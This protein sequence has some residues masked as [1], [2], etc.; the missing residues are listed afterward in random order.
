MLKINWFS[1][2]PPARTG[3]ADYTLSLLSELATQTHSTADL[4]SWTNQES[5][6]STIDNVVEV[7]QFTASTDWRTEFGNA[8]NIYNI[9]NNSQ[10]HTWIWLISREYPGIIILHDIH[11]QHLF[12]AYY[13]ESKQQSVYLD[14]MQQY[15]G[16]K[17][18]EDAEQFFSGHL[19]IN[20]LSENYPLFELAIK[21]NKGVIVHTENAVEKLGSRYTVTYLPLP[22]PTQVT[23]NPVERNKHSTPYQLIIFGHLGTNRR[24]DSVLRA[25]TFFPKKEQF[26]L[27]IYGAISNEKEIKNRIIE[28]GLSDI[29]RIHGFVDNETLGNALDKADL[30]VNLRHPTMGEASLSQLQIWSHALPSIVTKTG[31][32]AEQ[33]EECVSF[34]SIENEIEDIVSALI[35]F[36][37]SPQ[38]F[39]DKG[40]RGFHL[41]K[42]KHSPAA[43]VKNL[44][45]YC[46][47]VSQNIKRSESN[48]SD[49]S[50]LLWS[51]KCYRIMLDITTLG[52]SLYERKAR[53]G[54][55]VVT[56]KILHAL[57]LLHKQG[58]LHVSFIAYG[59]FYKYALSYYLSNP[60][61]HCVSLYSSESTAPEVD[62]YHCPY[63]PFPDKLSAKTFFL[64][65]YDLIPIKFSHWFP[66]KANVDSVLNRTFNFIAAHKGYALS[67]SDSTKNDLLE[68]YPSISKE[69]AL[70]TEL[71]ADSKKFYPCTEPA[72]LSDVY[73]KYQ[74]PAAPY[75][76]S[77]C[78]LEPRKNLQF[79]IQGFMRL[80][81]ENKTPDLYLVLVGTKGWL[82]DDIFAE[83]EKHP[84]YKERIIFTGYVPD[85]DLAPLY[86]GALA[87][88]YMS[89]Y[90]GFG[91]PPLE[92]MQ[93]GT[94]VITS[95]TSSLPEVVGEGGLMLDPTDL[96]A[97]CAA[98]YEMH[99]NPAH[100]ADM[101]EKALARAKLFSWERF[102]QQTLDAYALAM[103]EHYA[104]DEVP[105]PPEDRNVRARQLKVVVDGVF[106]Q[107]FKTG[108]A[109]VW[110]TL[111]HWWVE[112]G[113][114]AHLLVLDRAGSLPKFEGVCRRQIARHDYA[115]LDEDR[116]LLQ[117]ICIE[118][119]ADIFISSYYT[120]PLTTP[121]VLLLHDMIPEALNAQMNHPM[122]AEK[123]ECIRYAS[124]YVCISHNTAADLQRFFPQ[125][126]ADRVS[127][128]WNGVAAHFFPASIDEI[129]SFKQKYGIKKPYFFVPGD[130]G[131]H[132]NAVLF[133]QA[134][135][136]LAN[137]KDLAIV[138]TRGKL[139]SYLSVYVYGIETHVLD[140][141]D[142][143]LRAAY[144]GA[145]A[146]VFPS[147]YE[148]FGLPVVEAFA[149]GCP[150]VSS[151]TPAIAEVAGDAAILVDPKSVEQLREALQRV[152][153]A[154]VREALM[155]QGFERKSLFSWDVLA[156]TLEMQLRQTAAR[157]PG[158]DMRC[159]PLHEQVRE[160]FGRGDMAEAYRRAE[161]HYR[162]A[163]DA[164]ARND[165]AAC[166]M[167]QEKWQDA[168]EHLKQ[169]IIENPHHQVAVLNLAY[170][171]IGLSLYDEALQLFAA[172][173][174]LSPE[175]ESLLNAALWLAAKVGCGAYKKDLI[176]RRDAVQQARV[177]TQPAPATP[178][179][180]EPLTT[181]NKTD[182]V[183][184]YQLTTPKVVEWVNQGQLDTAISFLQQAVLHPPAGTDPRNDLGCVLLLNAQTR[185][186]GLAYLKQNAEQQPKNLEVVKNLIRAYL[187]SEQL[188]NAVQKA[189][190]LSEKFPKDVETLLLL[191]LAY[192][193]QGNENKARAAWQKAV[194]LEPKN[195]TLKAWVKNA[196][197]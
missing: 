38:T 29:V 78:T 90:E 67:I 3:I 65:V 172:L 113:F 20:R 69:K 43:Y 171:Y 133:F 83:Y 26:E 9:G 120:M 87:F 75:I 95:N 123:H 44:I 195:A 34:I 30:A 99:S 124:S 167:V 23:L 115:K 154:A 139:E 150:V 58:K 110:Q 61:F 152:Q 111:L 1:P 94:P 160:A 151:T 193:R 54:I 158:I 59:G 109:R 45:E 91:L 168:F 114:A 37:E 32:Y 39:Y 13:M 50:N 137:K 35:Q 85:E 93:C 170:T 79:V 74:I 14:L 136:Q 31:W 51:S 107:Y 188:Q 197:R 157:R 126:S 189:R 2:L 164:Q 163:P 7:K 92:A 56:E 108:I 143:A 8:L 70:V 145:I 132:K 10:F 148:G 131:V 112:S 159:A 24:L 156:D 53:T 62:I 104:E 119:G 166:L 176:E 17:G 57:L 161:A 105:P 89:L 103:R 194:K 18:K 66:E 16:A 138:C 134:F 28:L 106:F 184:A 125:V 153:Q 181:E 177:D 100:R 191:G 33:P 36:T 81:Q 96:E 118:E 41:L 82:Y 182:A 190:K 21:N 11:L 19:D 77:V 130:R 183:L 169:A 46:L 98:L 149:C 86:S 22:Y 196:N 175:D 6:D 129:G 135:A 187:L 47:S 84:E 162:N 144:S 155:A 122:W 179:P 192:A 27:H 72:D 71:A 5:W 4:T 42:E 174:A 25:L 117:Q 147:L 60:E 141:S 49:V 186:Q 142:E 63:Q 12:L 185:E 88:V 64:T 146:L 48:T 97:F 116:Q 52:A 165:L 68:Y 73:Q 15:Y 101:A 80:L 140:L 173:Y 76:L 178:K 127:V 102:A 180:A 128:A 55:F 121:A 40:A